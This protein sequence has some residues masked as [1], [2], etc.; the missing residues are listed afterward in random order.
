MTIK[1]CEKYIPKII[2]NILG[3]NN[4]P[5]HGDGQ[6]I[7]DWVH[8]LDHCQGIAKIVQNGKAGNIYNIG[9]TINQDRI[10]QQT[11]PIATQRIR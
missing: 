11:H 4:V 5:V 8:V 1:F 2:F 7:R 9:S 3:G 6:N 10:E